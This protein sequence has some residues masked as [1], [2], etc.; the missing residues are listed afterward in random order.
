MAQEEMES[1]TAVSAAGEVLSVR[2][3]LVGNADMLKEPSAG[4][5]AADYGFRFSNSL[6]IFILVYR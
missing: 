5:G 2:D 6:L 1:N 3:E 4:T